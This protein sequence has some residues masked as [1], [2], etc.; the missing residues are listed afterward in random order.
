MAARQH[1]RDVNVLLFGKSGAGK[2]TLGNLLIQNENFFKVTRGPAAVGEAAKGSCLVD[3]NGDRFKMNIF[4][5]PGLAEADREDCENLDEII[6]CIMDII[7]SGEPVIHVMIYVLSAAD[8]FTKDDANIFKYFADEGRNFWSHVMLVITSGQRYGET[9]EE[10]HALLNHSLQAPRCSQ[11]LK[12]LIEKI[13]KPRI[14]I[15]ESKDNND[16][17]QVKRIK[18]CQMIQELSCT[19]DEGCIYDVLLRAKRSLTRS[20]TPALAREEIRH[21]VR[22]E[23]EEVKC[24]IIK[25]MNIVDSFNLFF[26]RGGGNVF[27]EIVLL[28]L[29]MGSSSC[30]RSIQEMKFLL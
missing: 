26:H 16:E 7:E 11:H 12:S 3:I 19:N 28:L 2:S 8:R 15:T 22:R 13:G 17:I 20:L 29:K 27:Q 14:V 21:N 25:I 1:R 18:L 5:M 10:R 4:D 30:T 6:D 24:Y 23:I 9:D